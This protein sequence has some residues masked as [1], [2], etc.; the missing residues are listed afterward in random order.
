[1]RP[2]LTRLLTALALVF[3]AGMLAAAPSTAQ[4]APQAI[5]ITGT[6]SVV[7]PQAFPLHV[8]TWQVANDGTYQEDGRSALTAQRTQ[9]FGRWT[10]QGVHVVMTQNT[11]GFVFDGTV[12]GGCFIGRMTHNGKNISSFTARRRGST[13]RDCNGDITI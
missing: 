7:I 4:D 2:I 11:E 9:V 6:W 3:A 5:G 1:M 8:F 13:V 12:S 10:L